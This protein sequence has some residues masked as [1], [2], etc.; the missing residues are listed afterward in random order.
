[1]EKITLY[2]SVRPDGGVTTSPRKPDGTYTTLY[3][4]VAADGCILTNGSS[5]AECVDTEA[6]E[7]WTEIEDVQ[8]LAPEARAVL[9]DLDAAYREGVD[10]L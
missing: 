10:S 6:P 2:R 8:E 1:M 9:S 5:T 3:R 4:L 7:A